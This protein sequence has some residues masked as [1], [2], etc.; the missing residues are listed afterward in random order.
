[1]LE[2]EKLNSCTASGDV[3]GDEDIQSY[4]TLLLWLLQK[5]AESNIMIIT[6]AQSQISNYV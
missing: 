2:T 1:M 3:W 4:L 6:L 5:N